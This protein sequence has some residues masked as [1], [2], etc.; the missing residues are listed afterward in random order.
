VSFLHVE[1][2][3]DLCNLFKFSLYSFWSLNQSTIPSFTQPILC[4][5]LRRNIPCYSV[6]I[7]LIPSDFKKVNVN[8]SVPLYNWPTSL[9][10]SYCLSQFKKIF[11]TPCRIPFWVTAVPK[12]GVLICFTVLFLGMHAVSPS[13]LWFH[14]F[15]LGW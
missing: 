7:D 1:V 9:L 14:L 3:A 11:R 15:C 5:R 4:Y 8:S 13:N 2:F 12:L 10:T 6:I